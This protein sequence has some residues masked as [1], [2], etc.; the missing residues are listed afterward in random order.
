MA[1]Q[2]A[3]D[4]A[5]RLNY[6]NFT[7]T[8]EQTAI[9]LS[10]M[11]GL[12]EHRATGKSPGVTAGGKPKR[13]GF[14][15][16]ARR[17][18]WADRWAL[19]SMM[20]YLYDS[21]C[22]GRIVHTYPGRKTIESLWGSV[23]APIGRFAKINE[24]GL[25][26][27]LA[28]CPCEGTRD[29]IHGYQGGS[30][31]IL[32][33]GPPGAFGSP[34]TPVSDNKDAEWY[35]V[36]TNAKPVADSD[37]ISKAQLDIQLPEELTDVIERRKLVAKLLNPIGKKAEELVM[38][39]IVR[40][41]PNNL[42]VALREH[43]RLRCFHGS[44]VAAAL[45]VYF[46][47]LGVDA[48]AGVVNPT[49]A[50]L[51]ATAARSMGCQF[52]AIP[53]WRP[54]GKR[55]GGVKDDKSNVHVAPKA[56]IL[57]ARDLVPA[58]DVFI[59]ATGITENLLL[60]GVRFT[61]KG[62]VSTHTLCLRS[63]TGAQRFINQRHFENKRRFRFLMPDRKKHTEKGYWNDAYRDFGYDELLSKLRD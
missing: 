10:L 40:D 45:S 35:F 50:I 1:M 63:G 44:S 16:P 52:Y 36:V 23:S 27:D 11:F 17:R 34:A 24:S 19:A 51:M 37:P 53:G 6:L 62:E 56:R 30:L 14:P 61:G 60:R 26:L 46:P 12:G 29:L 47:G 3:E 59:V 21:H 42:I 31:S 33:G 57:K 5:V 43:A 25:N 58:D 9:L 13:K 32:A 54:K 41:Q 18:A 28:I 39:T 7:R 8:T 15:P 49:S 22:A 38:A 2:L 55:K 4:A 48:F 20:G